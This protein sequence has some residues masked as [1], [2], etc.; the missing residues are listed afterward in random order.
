MDAVSASGTINQALYDEIVSANFS[1]LPMWMGFDDGVFNPNNFHMIPNTVLACA[2]TA[3]GTWPLQPIPA[4]G[5]IQWGQLIIQ[6]LREQINKIMLTDPFG[7]LNDP[8]KTATEIIERQRQFLDNAAAKFARLQRELFDPFVERVIDILRRKGHW[9]DIE[10]DGKIIDVQYETPL[11][12][13]EG[14][15]EVLEMLQHVQFIQSIFG[16]QITAGFYKIEDISVWAAEKLNVNLEVLKSKEEIL[17][18]LDIVEKKQAQMAIQG[19]SANQQA[20][21]QQQQTA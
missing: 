7:P 2:P 14:Q 6:D 19:P 10:V 4:S 20:A 3:S 5:S 16:P 13:S 9:A 12:V 21:P 17:E 18:Q 1:A 15:K 8:T 11:V